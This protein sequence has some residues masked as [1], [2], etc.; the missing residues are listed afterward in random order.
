[1]FE[2]GNSLI[3]TLLKKLLSRVSTL[4]D[5]KWTGQIMIEIN[6]SQGTPGSVFFTA[7]EKMPVDKKQKKKLE[8]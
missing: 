3:E 5:S 4:V 2:S 7:K 8:T 1:V 6:M